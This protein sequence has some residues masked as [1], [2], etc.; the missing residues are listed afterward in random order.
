MAKKFISVKSS[1]D[2]V[3]V[4][5]LSDYDLFCEKFK[6]F[7]RQWTG[8]GYELTQITDGIDTDLIDESEV[9]ATDTS[10]LEVREILSEN[11]RLSREN[12]ALQAKLKALS[13]SDSKELTL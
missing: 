9:P 5:N 7:R 8:S 3:V 13:S 6:I 12:E 11:N 1:W 10:V 4:M 2:M